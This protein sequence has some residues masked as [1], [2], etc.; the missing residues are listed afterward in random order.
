MKY[1]NFI[2]QNVK[3]MEGKDSGKL[4]NM[5]KKMA[6]VVKTRNF[7]QCKSHHQKLLKKL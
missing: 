3:F 1:A 2:R 4:W 7:L 6:K 5:F